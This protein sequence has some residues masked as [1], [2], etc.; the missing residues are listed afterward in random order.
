MD[1]LHLDSPFAI[2]KHRLGDNCHSQFAKNSTSNAAW[3]FRY[4]KTTIEV[5]S[6]TEPFFNVIASLGI[7][8]FTTENV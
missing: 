3:F 1:Q 7:T 6:S 4:D 2:V 5:R 8:D